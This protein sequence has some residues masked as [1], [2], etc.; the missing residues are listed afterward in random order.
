VIKGRILLVDDEPSLR[1]G[2]RTYLETY[3][4][5]VVEVDTCGAALGHVKLE[6]PD[7]VLLDYVLPDGNALDVLRSFKSSGFDVPVIVLAGHGS[8][9]LAV[10]AIK[11]GAEYFVTKP[12]ELA[13]LVVMVDRLIE[14]QQN[15]RRAQAARPRATTPH[16]DDLLAGRS[17][18]IRTLADDV[19]S[20]AA[21][22][23]PVLI[24]GETGTGKGV[25]ARRIHDASMRSR[26][27]LVDLNCAGLSRDLLESELFGHE[28]GA[29]TGA[30]GTKRGLIEAA[31]RGTMFLD[32]IGDTDLAVQPKLLKVIEEKRFRRLGDTAERSVDVRFIMATNRNL[33]QLVQE[34]KFREDLYYRI[35]T[36]VLR[37]PPLRQHKEDIPILAAQLLQQLARDIR[38]PVPALD[39]D[40]EDALKAHNWPGNVRELRNVLERALLLSQADVLRRADLRLYSAS[41]TP[42][43]PPAAAGGTLKDLEWQYIDRVLEEEG[44][45]V[46]RA[47][48]RLGIPRS[49]MYQ[50][51]KLRQQHQLA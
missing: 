19:R 2:I 46:P 36:M 35:N 30:V 8:I 26:E 42:S 47:A 25:L 51:L 9:E 12:I 40:A 37:L 22:D 3:G 6:L 28:K 10:Q 33:S 20:I 41:A 17:V 38:R 16:A 15:T 7:V 23:T 49:T 50:R 44:G 18:A 11:E 27:A 5:T 24:E 14:H 39:P 31:H 34:G 32:E 21:S 13:S 29:F 48:K 1:L 45:N 4:Y 43:P